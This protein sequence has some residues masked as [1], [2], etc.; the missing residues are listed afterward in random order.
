MTQARAGEWCGRWRVCCACP[1]ASR[2][3]NLHN[4][5]LASV[6][7]TNAK[8]VA[9]AARHLGKSSPVHLRTSWPISR[10]GAHTARSCGPWATRLRRTAAPIGERKRGTTTRR[11]QTGANLHA[12]PIL[13]SPGVELEVV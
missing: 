8:L 3:N 4:L 13:S 6:P 10:S 7:L 5:L 11:D 1:R 2:G 9:R 12:L